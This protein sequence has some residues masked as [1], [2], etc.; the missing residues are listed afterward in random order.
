MDILL[1][2]NIQEI[3]QNTEDYCTLEG[4]RM[5]LVYEMDSKLIATIS[6]RSKELPSL[7]YV[8][9]ELV[10]RRLKNGCFILIKD[11]EIC[12]H[13][14]VHEH[15]VK[16]HSVFERSSLW[17]DRYYRNY[18]LGLL[19]MS[20]MTKL[21][22]DKFLISIAQ[23]PKVHHYNEL[24]AMTHVKLANMSALFVDEL[25]KLGKLRDELNYKYFVNSKFKKE[26]KQLKEVKNI[27]IKE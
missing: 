27:F 8:H 23:T 6:K 18:N 16:G 25:E 19:L 7:Y 13:I 14:F 24:L 10:E 17:V 12:G 2:K 21:Y 11:D 1:N 9:E 22:N 4:I 3:I 20:R 5:E 26:I 15:H